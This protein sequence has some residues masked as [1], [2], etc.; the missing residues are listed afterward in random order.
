M[1][2]IVSR[3]RVIKARC[4]TWYGVEMGKQCLKVYLGARAFYFYRHKA[5][6]RK[7]LWSN[8]GTGKAVSFS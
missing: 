3:K 2:R 6:D 1:V 4:R 8:H 7:R 5:S